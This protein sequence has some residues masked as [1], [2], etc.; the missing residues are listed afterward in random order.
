MPAPQRRLPTHRPTP[1]G[2]WRPPPR[3]RCPATAT[4]P[5]PRTTPWHDEQM[6]CDLLHSSALAALGRLAP[7]PATIPQQEDLDRHLPD[8]RRRVRTLATAAR[9]RACAA[10]VPR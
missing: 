8:A 4:G 3:A 10:P 6:S 7:E 1:A 2:S 9:H 5:R